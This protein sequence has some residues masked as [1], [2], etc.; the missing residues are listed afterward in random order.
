MYIRRYKEA[1]C[2]E[3]AK[4]FY[5]TVHTVNAKDYTE[6]QL[7]AWATGKVDLNEWNNS[8]LE[9]ISF[10]AVHNDVIV[11]FGDIDNKGYLD[12]LYVRSY[13]QRKGIGTAICNKLEESVHGNII[14]YAS[15]TAK[16]FFKRRGYK[17]SKKQQ[18]RKNDVDLINFVMEK[19]R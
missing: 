16:E 6:K 10:V 12:R 2:E 19:E 15:V 7:D 8:F 18:V 1:D 13:C 3:L 17:I 5:D 4:L 11:G 9:H 14:T